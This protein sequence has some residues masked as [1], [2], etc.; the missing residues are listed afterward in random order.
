MEIGYVGALYGDNG[1]NGYSSYIRSTLCMHFQIINILSFISG[2]E[3]G[4]DALVSNSIYLKPLSKPHT[5]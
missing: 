3:P 2:Y 4:L 5:K 1:D